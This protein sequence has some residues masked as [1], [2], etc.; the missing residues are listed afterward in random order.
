MGLDIDTRFSQQVWVPNLPTMHLYAEFGSSHLIRFLGESRGRFGCT[1]AR[2][3]RARLLTTHNASLKLV[4]VE[5]RKIGKLQIGAFLLEENSFT[6]TTDFIT[7]TLGE[8]P[9]QR[10]LFAP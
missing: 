9:T 6:P 4:G 2:K 1:F 10:I 8:G 7:G 3:S 5:R